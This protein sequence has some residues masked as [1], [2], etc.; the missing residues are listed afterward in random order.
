MTGDKT[1]PKKKVGQQSLATFIMLGLMVGGALSYFVAYPT[2]TEAGE[3]RTRADALDQELERQQGLV[4]QLDS[5][6]ATN[7]TRE[8]DLE[9]FNERF[10]KRERFSAMLQGL[11]NEASNN[12]VTLGNVSRKIAASE[13][14]GVDA[15]QIEIEAKGSYENVRKF[16]RHFDEGDRFISFD[17]MQFRLQDDQVNATLNMTSYLLRNA[18]AEAAPAPGTTPAGEGTAAGAQPSGG[19]Q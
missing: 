9:R 13:V 3:A 1:K 19:S 15:M 2:Y 6:K 7:K 16:I 8:A 17:A 10:P 14:P 11:E 4:E 5:L 12:K 18:K